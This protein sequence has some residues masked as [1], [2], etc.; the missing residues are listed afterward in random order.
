MYNLHLECQCWY[1]TYF[2]VGSLWVGFIFHHSFHGVHCKLLDIA[3]TCLASQAHYITGKISL[4]IYIYRGLKSIKFI[5]HHMLLLNL[6][7]FLW[8]WVWHSELQLLLRVHCASVVWRPGRLFSWLQ[9]HACGVQP[10]SWPLHW[11]LPVCPQPLKGKPHRGWGLVCKRSLL[12]SN[13]DP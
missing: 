4:V 5:V 2:L 10:F 12:F 1:I 8:V 9:L 6:F 3:H 7:F 11:T 13:R